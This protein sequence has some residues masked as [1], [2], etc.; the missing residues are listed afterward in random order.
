[1]QG[2]HI[3]GVIVAAG[4]SSRMGRPK[5]MIELE[6][7]MILVRLVK[8]LQEA[9]LDPVIVVASGEAMDAALM[10]LSGVVLVEGDPDTEMIDSIAHGIDRAGP[11]AAG[12]VVQPVDAP[13]TTKAMV[14]ALIEGD[15]GR[16]R[17]LAS[18]GVAGHPAYVPRSAFAA[19]HARPKGGLRA[20]LEEAGAT[21]VAWDDQRVLA[22]LDTPEDLARWLS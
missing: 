14:D 5:A 11:L 21:F 3:A 22:D 20:V 4:R 7:E 2:E 15:P 16:A 17:V 1:V 18:G 12:V 8:V 6:G 19:V 13:F 10:E 9:G